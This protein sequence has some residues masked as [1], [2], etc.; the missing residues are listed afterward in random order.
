MIDTT[1][2]TLALRN[3]AI[4]L[5]VCTTGS[6]SLSATTTGY[7]RAAGSF[8]T[9]GFQPGMETLPSGWSVTGNNARC[10]ITQVTASDL[11]IDG[12]R[13]VEA[14]GSGKTIA[15]GLPGIRIWE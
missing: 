13:S 7:H 11:T 9:D 2:A 4:G 15:V 6:T 10:V 14:A 3:R 1:A 12:G 8:I 5:V